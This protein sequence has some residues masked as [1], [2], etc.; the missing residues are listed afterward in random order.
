[1]ATLPAVHEVSWVCKVAL[2]TNP[3]QLG[4][5]LA[6]ERKPIWILK[7]ALR[8][9]HGPLLLRRS[10]CAHSRGAASVDVSDALKSTR[11][12]YPMEGKRNRNE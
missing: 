6:T 1:V 3:V 8:T 9:V 4:T 7:L 10:H 2:R 12:I 11:R 5:A